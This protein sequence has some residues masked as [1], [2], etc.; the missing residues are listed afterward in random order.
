MMDHGPDIVTCGLQSSRNK[1]TML[2]LMMVSS[3]PL[4]PTGVASTR[5]WLFL[6]PEIGKL[7][8]SKDLMLFTKVLNRPIPLLLSPTQLNKMLWSSA[9]NTPQD[10]GHKLKTVSASLR[11]TSL[12]LIKVISTPVRIIIGSKQLLIQLTFNAMD[13][14]SC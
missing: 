11:R 7:A 9:T 8:L 14:L 2:Q 13:N 3:I 6:T 10:F 5:T 4:S 12:K 1:L